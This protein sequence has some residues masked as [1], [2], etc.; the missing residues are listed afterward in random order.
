MMEVQFFFLLMLML[1]IIN[2]LELEELAYGGDNLPNLAFGIYLDKIWGGTSN[3]LVIDT[4]NHV[5]QTELMKLFARQGSNLA[6]GSLQ[7]IQK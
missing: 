3:R 5:S 4:I 7:Y 1:L 6:I 2:Q